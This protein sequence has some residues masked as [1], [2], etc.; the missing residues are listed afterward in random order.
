MANPLTMKLSSFVD[1]S[2]ADRGLLDHLASS[3]SR[4]QAGQ[5]IIR[6]GER[7]ERVILLLSGW[8]YR[9]KILSNGNRQI[10]AY[11][12]PGDLCDAHVFIL[13]KMDH[14]I[15]LLSDALVSTIS[16]ETMLDVTERAPVIARALWWSTLVDEAVLRH[17][18]INLG[19]RDA[20]GRAAH[21]FCEL[22]ERAAKVGLVIDN[23][24]N[25]PLTQEQLGDSL[26]ITPIHTN[27]ILQRMR[28]DGL[29]TFEDKRLTI[30]DMQGMR[31]VA[32][33]DSNYLHQKRRK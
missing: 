25:L 11:L 17:W 9:Y 5:D 3:T 12:L 2:R 15:G 33:F 27:R 19:R 4:M 1:L 31:Q 26:G 24:F 28:G 16:R 18:L 29:I 6:E 22:W 14:S 13:D 21:L 10:V 30:L 20:Y 23:A 32:D 8:A 7:P